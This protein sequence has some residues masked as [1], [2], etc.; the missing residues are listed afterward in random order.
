MRACVPGA[1]GVTGVHHSDGHGAGAPMFR[2]RRTA[3]TR[4][5][6]EPR[7]LRNNSRKKKRQRLETERHRIF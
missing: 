4:L 3:Q 5:Y 7:K 1:G 2:R 6:E